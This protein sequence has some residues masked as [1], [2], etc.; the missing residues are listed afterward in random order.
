[1]GSA[2][3]RASS[4]L[5]CPEDNDSI[6]G[7]DEE[8]CRGGLPPGQQCRRRALQ[9]GG[10]GPCM[11]LPLQSDACLGALVLRESQH[12]PRD[13]YA[14]R[15][16]TG[17]LDISVRR[18]AIDWICKVHAYYSFGPH[19]AYLSVNYLDRFLSFY[20][21]PQ[22]KAWMTQLLSVTCLSLAAKMEETEVPL[23]LDLQIGETKFVFEAR[24][25]QRM[26][27]LVLSTL[28][29]RMQA[30]TPFSYIDY[31]LHIFNGCKPPQESSLSQS[32]ELI[33]RITRSI[34]FLEFWPS[35]VAAAAALSQFGDDTMALNRCT[36][37]NKERVL[38]CYE[39]IRDPVLMPHGPL[40]GIT[41]TVS[42]VPQSPI[43][44]LDVACLSSKSHDM[45]VGSQ[46]SPEHSSP[47]AKRRK[48]DK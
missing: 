17:A 6:L 4:I 26:E 29:W 40:K 11:D 13:D 5:L 43:G 44:V 12:L 24:T 18:D 30:V 19:S 34:D 2:Y 35:E 46:A 16:Q 47:D 10:D 33:L 22:G 42:S 31:F 3:D 15:L 37:V 45:T 23:S 1:M 8:D 39:L 20:E 25:I 7:F 36:H 41:G 32:V 21:L 9:D 27:L 48:L 28:N 38:R 14:R